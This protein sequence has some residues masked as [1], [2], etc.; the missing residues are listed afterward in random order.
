MAR[1]VR[2]WFPV[3]LGVVALGALA[4]PWVAA[5]QPAA[6]ADAR[7]PSGHRKTANRAVR[8]FD[9][10]NYA[11]ARGLFNR[12]HDVFPNA[13]TH[14]GLGLCEYE[15]RNYGTSIEHLEQALASQVKPLN[16]QLRKSA[17]DVLGKARDL[18]GR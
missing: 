16:Q 2:G 10:G 7:E 3:L 18:I 13:R 15:L 12:A 1:A 4:A 9:A 6:R 8:E 17:E 14:L 5:A 11:E